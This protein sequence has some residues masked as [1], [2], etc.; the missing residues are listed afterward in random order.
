MA[1]APCWGLDCGSLGG[2]EQAGRESRRRTLR[3]LGH[4]SFPTA[5]PQLG[6][7]ASLGWGDAARAAGRWS[8]CSHNRPVSAWVVLPLTS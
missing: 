3:M 6:L 4:R 1:A 8:L 7:H 2:E 5:R